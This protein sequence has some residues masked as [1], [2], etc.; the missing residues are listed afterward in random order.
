MTYSQL[1]H[2]ARQIVAR[3][4]LATSQEVQLGCDWYPSALKIAT[5]IADKYDLRVET[6]AGVISAL[7]PSN[8][9]ERN[10]FDAEALIKVWR[11]GATRDEVLHPKHPIIRVCTYLTMKTKAWDIL[12]REEYQLPVPIVD[13]LKGVK[14][15]E[16]FNCITNPLLDDV[17]IDGHAYSVWLGD[18]VV[19]DKV[20]N[21]Q[22]KI[23]QT[24][25]QD[26]RDATT[27]INDELDEDY[28]TATI[29]AVTWV[30]HKRIHNV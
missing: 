1:S 2:N 18:R 14:V 8:K 19:L 21:I 27:F 20:P 12:M 24:I 30:T 5:R 6:V 11:A 13:I 15:V 29:Q 9:W 25:K 16:F 4:S 10:I 26:Y 23:R 3:F 28:S 17:C 22:G 7:S